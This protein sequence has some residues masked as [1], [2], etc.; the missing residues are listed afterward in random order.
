MTYQITDDDGIICRYFWVTGVFSLE[1]LIFFIHLKIMQAL[2]LIHYVQTLFGLVSC[3]PGD[4][5]N[6]IMFSS[7]T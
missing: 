7:G 4:E 3:F 1:Q 2:L 6:M 5:L